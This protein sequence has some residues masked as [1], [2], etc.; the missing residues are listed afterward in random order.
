MRDEDSLTKALEGFDIVINLAAEHRDD[1]I[2]RSLY[3][4]VN[5]MGA[6]NVCSACERLGINKIIFTKFI[7]WKIS[8]VS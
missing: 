4:D 7:R 8:M 5:V 3:D 2:P 1:V 6:E